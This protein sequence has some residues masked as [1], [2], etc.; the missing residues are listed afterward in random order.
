[1]I[2]YLLNL[3]TK[4]YEILFFLISILGIFVASNRIPF[5][6]ILAVVIFIFYFINILE[7][8]INLF[9]I[10]IP[11]ILFLYQSNDKLSVKYD[12][13]KTKIGRSIDAM[14]ENAEKNAFSLQTTEN[15]LLSIKIVQ[16]RHVGRW[17]LKIF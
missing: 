9:I 10:L 16:R 13:L 4:Y 7:K 2:K 15:L 6:I 3:E 1:M 8:I 11:T 5:L 14:N 12:D 17:R